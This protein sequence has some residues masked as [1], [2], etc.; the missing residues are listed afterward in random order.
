MSQNQTKVTMYNLFK[1]NTNV[2]G[3]FKCLPQ[4][5]YFNLV[6]FRTANHKLPIETGRWLGIPH[7]E[8]KCTLCNNNDLGDEFHYLLVCPHFSDKR[9][10]YIKR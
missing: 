3:Y 7:S 5:L 9:E 6:R 1:D 10:F 8:R 2:E 4:S